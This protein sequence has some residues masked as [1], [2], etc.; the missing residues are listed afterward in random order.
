MESS[1]LDIITLIRIC[2]V[3]ADPGKLCQV[4]IWL[5]RNPRTNILSYTILK[6]TS[7]RPSGSNLPQISV[8]G[9]NKCKWQLV[10]TIHLN[11]SLW[12]ATRLIVCVPEYPVEAV[13]YAQHVENRLCRNN[14]TLLSYQCEHITGMLSTRLIKQLHRSKNMKQYPGYALSRPHTAFLN[15]FIARSKK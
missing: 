12:G 1:F 3:R 7:A 8:W 11:T 9:L 6:T 13:S 14:K 15:R 10:Y 5:Y 4:H 2:G